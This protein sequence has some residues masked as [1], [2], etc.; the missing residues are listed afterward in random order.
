VS[1]SNRAGDL[2]HKVSEFLEAGTKL[3][4]V[5]DPAREAVVVH[6]QSGMPRVM[7]GRER[8]ECAELMPGLSLDVGALF[9]EY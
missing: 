9:A 2:L 3:V 7:R 1:P 5:I 8:M 4:W 6:D